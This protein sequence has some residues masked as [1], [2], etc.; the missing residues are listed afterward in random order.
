VAGGF[1]GALSPADAAFTGA[2]SPAGAA[3]TGALSPAG[4]AFIG[5]R[6]AVVAGFFSAVAVFG[7]AA[8]RLDAGV[9]SLSAFAPA[10]LPRP[11]GSAA[12][13]VEARDRDALT[14]VA[15]AFAALVRVDVGRA[16]FAVSS[17]VVFGVERERVGFAFVASGPTAGGFDAV[18]LAEVAAAGAL[19]GAAD[20]PADGVLA[21]AGRAGGVVPLA[22][23]P[24]RLVAVAFRGRV[25]FAATVTLDSPADA[26]VLDAEALPRRVPE[27]AGEA[28]RRRTA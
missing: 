21:A 3:F 9:A 16:G 12:L 25:W 4:A 23:E 17:A 2:L 13:P 6:R 8:R 28:S 26:V 1:T 15:P 18:P 24:A 10:D 27:P 22:V 11:V 19:A 5:A 14:G 7:C 20:R